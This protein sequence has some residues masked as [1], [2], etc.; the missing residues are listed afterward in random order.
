MACCA[1]APCHFRIS[2]SEPI[3]P[4][5]PAEPVCGAVV[6]LFEPAQGWQQGLAPL[7]LNVAAGVLVDNS[8]KPLVHTPDH[9]QYI[10]LGGNQGIAAATN[11]GLAALR[12]SRCTH[13]L[14]LDQDSRLSVEDLTRLRSTLPQLPTDALGAVPGLAHPLPGMRCRWPQRQS[15]WHFRFVYAHSLVQPT[16]IHVA[17]SSGMLLDLRRMAAL[18]DFDEGLF[19][20]LV[21]TDLCLRALK[22]GWQLYAVPH[23]AMP[24]A[25]G[26]PQAQHILGQAAF[27]THHPARRHYT[28]ARNRVL[29]MR[30]HAIDAP[31]WM[32]YE[33]LGAAKLV[34][35]VLLFEPGRLIKLRAMLRGTWDGLRGRNGPPPESS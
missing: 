12:A 34:L 7:R 1:S 20:D 13:A 16:A 21:D 25:I 28:L 23:T 26:R 2:V 14:L 22:R 3:S 32:F 9:W 15:A 19:I 30:R 31:F 5:C 11:R 24:H 27:P 33:W 18:G 4:P 10:W 35:K 29:L 17:I 6:V 8:A